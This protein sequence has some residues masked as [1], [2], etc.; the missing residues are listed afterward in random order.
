MICIEVDYQ[1]E[2]GAI[3]RA[4]RVLEIPIKARLA[5]GLQGT[6]SDQHILQSTLLRIFYRV[7]YYVQPKLAPSLRNRIVLARILHRLDF[8]TLHKAH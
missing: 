4:S 2:L 5:A 1:V 3:N 7:L 8:Y 6:D